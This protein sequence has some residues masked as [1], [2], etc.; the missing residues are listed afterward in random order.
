MKGAI[1]RRHVEGME[2]LDCELEYSLLMGIGIIGLALELRWLEDW[3]RHWARW[4]GVILPKALEHRP[5]LRPFAM[6][7]TGEIPPRP[8]LVEP[9][10]ENGFLHVYVPDRSGSGTWHHCMDEPYMQAEVDYLRDLG[11]VDSAE[12]RRYRAWGRKKHP[13]CDTCWA[14]TY[15]LEQG[16]YE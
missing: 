12:Y 6:Y 4:R 10:K 3:K 15:P 9:P 7:V 2:I 16:L 8:V 11:I 13:H 5:G 1:R 14:D